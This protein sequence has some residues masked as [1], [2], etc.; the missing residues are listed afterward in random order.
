MRSLLETCRTSQLD[1]DRYRRTGSIADVRQAVGPADTTSGDDWVCPAFWDIQI[2]GRWGHSF[3]SPELT[4]EQVVAIVRA[5][6]AL[7]TARL[8][9]TLITAPLDDML[10][11]LTHHRGGL[12]EDPQTARM[13]LGIHLEGPFLSDREGYRGAHPAA[14]MRDPDWRCSTSSRT[15]PAEPDRA[16]YPGARA[17]R[18]LDLFIAGRRRSGWSVALGHTAADGPNIRHAAGAGATLSTHLGN[19]I[20]AELPRHPNPIWHQAADDSLFA[21]LIADGHHLDAATLRVLARAKG[22]EQGHPVSDASPLA[23]LPPGTYGDG[24]STLGKIVVAGTAY[25][26][27]S[28]QSLATGLAQPD[29]R[30]SHGHSPG[31]STRD[32][33]PGRPAGPLTSELRPGRSRPTLSSFATKARD[34]VLSARSWMESGTNRLLEKECQPVHRWKHAGW[35]WSSSADRALTGIERQTRCGVSLREPLDRGSLPGTAHST[36]PIQ[37]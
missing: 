9:P 35:P 5:Q 37:A 1:R 8:C 19:G 33:Q 12:H 21:S 15:P 10:H 30:P 6:G 7:G 26:A 18:A 2:N 13:V 14:A 11:G 34:F 17:A 28:N 23:G 16:H 32:S 29:A 31:F 24:P 22:A 27:G 36:C 25:L 20:A 4:V 3:S